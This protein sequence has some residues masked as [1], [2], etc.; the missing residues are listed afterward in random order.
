MIRPS[1]IVLEA[2]IR[3]CQQVDQTTG[4][5]K[6]EVGCRRLLTLS[7][8]DGYII[9]CTQYRVAGGQAQH[10][11]PNCAE[12]CC[13]SGYTWIAERDCAWTANL[14]PGCVEGTTKR[15]TII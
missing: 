3:S 8:S 7:D 10:V 13:S 12:C 4:S 11:R 14:N 1:T 6:R 15:I 5:R 2:G 9:G